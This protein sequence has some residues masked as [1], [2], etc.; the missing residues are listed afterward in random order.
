MEPITDLTELSEPPITEKGFELIMFVPSRTRAP[1]GFKAE[2]EERGLKADVR[3]SDYGLVLSVRTERP[4]ELDALLKTFV[5]DMS[6]SNDIKDWKLRRFEQIL[7]YYHVNDSEMARAKQLPNLVTPGALARGK[8]VDQ[9][10]MKKFRE[11]KEQ[12]ALTAATVTPAIELPP[13]DL[14]A[15][16]RQ[17]L[18]ERDAR[19]E[20]E[21]ARADATEADGKRSEAEHWAALEAKWKEQEM[22]TKALLAVKEQEAVKMAYETLVEWLGEGT[23]DQTFQELAKAVLD[24]TLRRRALDRLITEGRVTEDAQGCHW[25][26]QD[27]E[28]QGGKDQ[29]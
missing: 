19:W 21:Q 18:A 14:E 5:H 29:D 23:M 10:D 11:M 7:F 6:W 24:D 15:A 22:A 13:S 16:D 20:E 4:E 27:P 3:A 8:T 12:H 1:R 28:G 2:C 26:E 9:A 17:R 25:V